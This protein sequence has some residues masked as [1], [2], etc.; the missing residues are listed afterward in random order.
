[1]LAVSWR[2]TSTPVGPSARWM[3]TKARSGSPPGKGERVLRGGGD[4][5]DVVTEI[6]QQAFEFERDQDFILYEE[7]AQTLLATQT[8]SPP[9]RRAT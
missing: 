8:V 9:R 1:M 3:S 6:L 7:D 4:A 5:D 2:A